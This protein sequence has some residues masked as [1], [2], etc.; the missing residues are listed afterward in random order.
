[1]KQR[2]CSNT[3]LY[4][5]RCSLATSAV[6][7]GVVVLIMKEVLRSCVTNA[8][9]GKKVVTG[10][11]FKFTL[12]LVVIVPSSPRAKGAVVIRRGP[13][14][15]PWPGGRTLH[16]P[17]QLPHFNPR[18][19][20]KTFMSVCVQMVFLGFLRFACLD[21]VFSLSWHLG[22]MFKKIPFASVPVSRTTV[23][24]SHHWFLHLLLF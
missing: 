11:F 1:M 3:R 13:T 12:L 6:I 14:T 18:V 5:I 4:L 20:N 23:S 22:C 2:D 24:P 21:C 10:V 7:G 19:F 9:I 16:F 8:Q 17:G 15:G